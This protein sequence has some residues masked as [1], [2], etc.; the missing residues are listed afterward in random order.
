MLI[1]WCTYFL[2][3]HVS[4]IIAH[5]TDGKKM[6]KLDA[7]M[8]EAFDKAEIMLKKEEFFIISLVAVSHI[9]PAVNYAIKNLA[10]QSL[11][12]IGLFHGICKT[13]ITQKE[14]YFT[15]KNESLLLRF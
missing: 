11:K 15:Q 12:I 10:Q 7:Y 13:Q 2:L 4:S 1:F 14:I 6:I 3:Q 8:S 5:Q 9:M